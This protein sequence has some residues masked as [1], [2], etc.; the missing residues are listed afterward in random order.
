MTLIIDTIKEN[1]P[2]LS[3]NTVKTYNS[4]LQALHKKVFPEKEI[5]LANFKNVKK[6]M[7]SLKDKSPST[8][9]TTLSALFILTNVPEYQN[10]MK[11]DIKTYKEDVAKREMTEKQKESFLSQDE[12]KAKLE[13]LRVQAEHLYKKGTAL[14]PADINQIQNYIILALASGVYVPPRRSLD[15]TA[16]KVNNKNINKEKDNY[17]EKSKFVFN[18]FKGSDKKGKQ[19]IPIPKPLQAILK[20]WLTVHNNDYLLFDVNGNPLNSVKMTQRLNRILK[21]GSAINTLRHSYLSSKY[22]DTIKLNEE[23]AKD[24]EKMGS[25]KNQENIYVQKING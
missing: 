14:T 22:Q 5:N 3:P 25:S 19:E 8:R 16:M 12:I 13:E 1:R 20:K 21:D 6:I 17:M 4:I 23:L 24:M 15:F 11:E 9:K 10:Q 7:E 2:N 18:Q